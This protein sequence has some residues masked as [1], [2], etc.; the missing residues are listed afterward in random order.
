LELP[1][2]AAIPTTPTGFNALF[3]ASGGALYG[4]ASHGATGT[5]A[6]PGGRTRLPGLYCAG[7]SVHPGP[8]IPMAAMS[9]RLAA[10]RVLEDLAGTRHRAI[11]LPTPA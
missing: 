11:A 3:P 10:A 5:F 1:E 8:G 4:R 9:G 7:G 6:R 2:Q